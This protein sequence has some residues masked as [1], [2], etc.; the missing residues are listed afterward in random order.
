MPLPKHEMV[1]KYFIF[2]TQNTARFFCRIKIKKNGS[3][4]V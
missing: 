3:L 2:Y 1:P 4:Y